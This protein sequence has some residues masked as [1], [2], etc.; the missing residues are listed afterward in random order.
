MPLKTAALVAAI[1]TTIACFISIIQLA[2][3]LPDMLAYL[4]IRTVLSLAS[5]SIQIVAQAALAVF[6]F[7]FYNRAQPPAPRPSA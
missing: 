1:L 6:L 3:S 2:L 5:W 7:A 4:E